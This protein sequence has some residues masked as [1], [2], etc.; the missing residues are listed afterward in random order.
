VLSPLS[1][2]GPAHASEAEQDVAT[3]RAGPPPGRKARRAKAI[4]ACKKKKEGQA[5]KVVFGEREREGTCRTIRDGQLACVPK[6]AEERRRRARQACEGKK[7]GEACKVQLRNSM[8]DGT[9]ID[10]PQGL[11]C[12]PRRRN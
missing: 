10:N 5:C 3:H 11:L 12:R 9:C 1:A 8:R 7:A 4:E 6:Q 2:C